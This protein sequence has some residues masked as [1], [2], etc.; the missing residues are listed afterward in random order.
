M[1]EPHRDPKMG[2]DPKFPLGGAEW[3][4]QSEEGHQVGR[5]E[6]RNNRILNLGP[7]ISP[8]G[9]IGG[10]GEPH[11]DPKV[12]GDPKISLWGGHGGGLLFP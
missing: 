6:P 7:Q 2:G 10:W 12:G 1:G 4:P 5:V 11:R 8:G 3:G 9:G